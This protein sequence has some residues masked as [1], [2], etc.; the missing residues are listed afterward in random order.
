MGVSQ[1][2]KE[3][4]NTVFLLAFSL[5]AVFSAMRLFSSLNISGSRRVIT[6]FNTL[7]FT[8]A[9]L[10]VLFCVLPYLFHLFIHDVDDIGN[11]RISDDVYHDT[12]YG[13][14]S[15][16][17]R[18]HPSTSEKLLV[19]VSE[20]V[21]SLGNWSLYGVFIIIACYWAYMLKKLYGTRTTQSDEQWGSSERASER[22]L[23]GEAGEVTTPTPIAGSRNGK[24]SDTGAN[25]YGT[26][27]LHTN[28]YISEWTRRFDSIELFNRIMVII[29]AIQVVCYLLY[30]YNGMLS[31]LLLHDALLLSTTAVLVLMAITYLSSMINQVLHT[32]EQTNR[33]AAQAQLQRIYMIIMVANVFFFTRVILEGGLAA[34]L[35]Y[36]ILGNYSLIAITSLLSSLISIHLFSFFSNKGENS[37]DIL[38]PEPYWTI[39]IGIKHST[40]IV[41]LILELLVSTAIRSYENPKVNVRQVPKLFRPGFSYHSIEPEDESSPEHSPS[42]DGSEIEL[43]PTGMGRSDFPVSAIRSTANAT[44][45]E[46]RPIIT[47]PQ[48]RR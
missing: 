3:S 17:D 37:H 47:P 42:I 14:L 2:Y 13:R 26:S 39:Y 46:M 9:L 27:V 44:P 28:R 12:I 11:S 24:T 43:G 30:L 31:D 10:R 16:H 40:E 35:W 36:L 4:Q 38:I 5:L 8:S 7:I 29:L 20:I 41:V 19:L 32:M 34:Y 18:M 23:G 25:V 48:R 15:S 1:S 22:E 6:Y 33:S 21:L 45:E